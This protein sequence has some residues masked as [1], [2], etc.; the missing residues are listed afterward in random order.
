[1]NRKDLDEIRAVLSREIPKLNMIYKI[2]LAYIF[3]SYAKGTNNDNSDIDIAILLEDGYSPLDK[4]GLLGELSD[5]LRADN[6]DLV[7]LN[8][9]N[10]VLKHQVIKYGKIVYNESE[11]LR[12]LFEVRVLKEYMDMDYFRK[13]QMHYISEWVSKE[14]EA[15]K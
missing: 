3:G 2:K 6:I 13:T 15:A 8:S 10:S 14:M 12:I 1:M 11:E 4:V 5:A 9:A 7:I